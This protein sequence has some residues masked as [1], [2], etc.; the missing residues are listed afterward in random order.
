[1]IS[2]LKSDNQMCAKTRQIN[3]KPIKLLTDRRGHCISNIVNNEEVSMAVYSAQF[4]A[5][6]SIGTL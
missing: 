3:S 1:M 6:Y 4:Q 5:P 2:I